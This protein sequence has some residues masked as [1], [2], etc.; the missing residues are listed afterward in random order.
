MA[1]STSDIVGLE[2]RIIAKEDEIKDLER[3]INSKEEKILSEEE[4]IL[5]S[6]ENFKLKIIHSNFIK[7]LNKHK[8]VYS[9]ITLVSI[10]LIWTGIQNFLTTVPFFHNPLV[11]I[12]LGILIV[13]I[14]DRE[15][16]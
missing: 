1:N 4:R 9:F 7:R 11:S 15:L 5:K 13:L 10:I 14:I 6:T 16:T 12:S 8:V 3:K 2:K